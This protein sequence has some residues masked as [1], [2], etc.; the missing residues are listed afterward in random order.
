MATSLVG[1][2]VRGLGGNCTLR[3]RDRQGARGSRDLHAVRH[4]VT[5]KWLPTGIRADYPSVRPW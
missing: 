2:H 1:F 4:P 5:L 3:S